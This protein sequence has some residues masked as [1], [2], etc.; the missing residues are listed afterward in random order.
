MVA[1]TKHNPVAI[2]LYNVIFGEEIQGYGWVDF[3]HT[4]EYEISDLASWTK[5]DG[6]VEKDGSVCSWK[7][8]ARED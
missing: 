4:K 1:L 5:A 3:Q 7:K 8:P 6:W 2:N